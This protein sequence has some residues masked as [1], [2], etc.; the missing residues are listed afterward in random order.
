MSEAI[1]RISAPSN[2]VFSVTKKLSDIFLNQGGGGNKSMGKSTLFLKAS[3]NPFLFANERTEM[4]L[5]IYLSEAWM[6][7][8]FGML[9]TDVERERV[10]YADQDKSNESPHYSMRLACVRDHSKTV[11]FTGP[12]CI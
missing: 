3:L 1:W 5:K 8:E 7:S 10:K 6:C 2:L 9:I 12:S 4:K 11:D